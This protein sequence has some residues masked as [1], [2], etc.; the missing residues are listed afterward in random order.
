MQ[1]SKTG[2]R[3]KGTPN[4]STAHIKN[5]LGRIFERAFVET[6]TLV[7]KDRKGDVIESRDVT[8]EEMLV[9]QIVTLT[10]DSKLLG[11]LLAYYAGSPARQITHDVKGKLTLEQLIAG[12]VSSA[13]DDDEA[14]E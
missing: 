1:G 4:K 6:K 12:A 9:E 3:T 10:I 13:D 8:L 11:T 14:D 2:G 5:F 7:R